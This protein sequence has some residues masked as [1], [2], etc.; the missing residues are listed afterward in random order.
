V[1][2]NFLMTVAMAGLGLDIS[3]RSMLRIGKN[4]FL[5]GVVSSLMLSALSGGIIYFM[6]AR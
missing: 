5:L 1:S 2:D 3:M 4:A 6:Y